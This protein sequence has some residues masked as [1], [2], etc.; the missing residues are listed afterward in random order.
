VLD[1][2]AAGIPVVTTDCFQVP[3]LSGRPS[4]GEVVA[5]G[6]ARSLA[7]AILKIRKSSVDERRRLG[8]EARRFSETYFDLGS[9]VR[10]MRDCMACILKARGIGDVV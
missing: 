7:A 5:V 1:A 4:W 8:E 10:E 9:R 3:G 2:W 6:D